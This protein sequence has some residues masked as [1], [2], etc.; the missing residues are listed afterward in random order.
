MSIDPRDEL[1]VAS[2]DTLYDATYGQVVADKLIDRWQ[3]IDETT[4]ALVALTA[5]GSAVSGWVLWSKPQFQIAWL[6]LSGI[7]AVLAILHASVAVPGHI[8]DHAED[9]RRFLSLM[10]DLETFRYE[11][12]INPVFDIAAFSTRFIEFRKRYSDT[13]QLVK[14]DIIL[15][16]RMAKAAQL[17][18]NSYLTSE[19]K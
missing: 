11:M 6:M 14:N 12:R 17:D 10:A 19:I 8:K 7:A 4:R 9:K 16:K 2:F 5:S 18:V 15:T 13:A 1:W 3:G